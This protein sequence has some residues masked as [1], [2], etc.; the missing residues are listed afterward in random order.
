MKTSATNR[1]LR[2]LL[3][4]IKAGTLIPRPEFQR[5]LV[6][7]NKHKNAFLRTVLEGL[8]FPEIYIAAGEVDED[9]GEGTEMLV[10]GQ[11]RI[12]TLYQ[13]FHGSSDLKLERSVPP[14]STLSQSEKMNFLEYEVVVRDLGAISL[15]QIKDVFTRIN[16]T[17]YSLNAM[18]INNAR[19][20][21]ELKK[22]AVSLAE[23]AFFEKY[24]TFSSRDT[25]RMEDVR[26]CLTLIVTAMSTYFNRD[27]ELEPYLKEYDEEFPGADKLFS[28]IESVLGIID[29]LELGANSRA[30][31]K[32][33]LFTL[34]VEL[35]RAKYRDNRDIDLGSLGSTLKSFYASVNNEAE[36]WYFG[37]DGS[38]EQYHTAALQASNDRSNRIKRAYV[39]RKLLFTRYVKQVKLLLQPIASGVRV[40]KCTDMRA[41]DQNDVLMFEGLGYNIISDAPDAVAD[42]IKKAAEWLRVPPESVSAEV[43]DGEPLQ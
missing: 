36:D 16:S 38:A 2:V 21:G 19:Y 13:Y 5:R 35:H 23:H 31:K 6:W 11:Q 28:Q 32:A 9:T 42:C 27:D 3:T 20:D 7:V 39:L 29:N 10:D 26:Y 24:R 12:T 41:Y 17:S 18:E 43:K 14:Y 4:A 33:D 1:K 34:I 40:L 30:F 37:E 22:R 8:P 15:E 25:R